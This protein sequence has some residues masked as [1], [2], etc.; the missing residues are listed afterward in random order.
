MLEQ[1]AADTSLPRQSSG[2]HGFDFTVAAV[3]LFERNTA[4]HGSFFSC[5]PECNGRVLQLADVERMNALRWRVRIHVGQVLTE[6]VDDRVILNIVAL[7]LHD[8]SLSQR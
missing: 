4:K 1:P 5:H 7:N 6:K 3:K 2:T 8:M